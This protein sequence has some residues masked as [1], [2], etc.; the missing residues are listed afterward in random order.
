MFK[1]K[2]N[3][4][5]SVIASLAILEVANAN[6]T[7]LQVVQGGH[8]AANY[9][10]LEC[11]GHTT[12][13]ELQN[14]LWDTK[15]GLGLGG[16]WWRAYAVDYY[17]TGTTDPGD[18][19][20]TDFQGAR[21]DA[22]HTASY[23]RLHFNDFQAGST[24][25]LLGTQATANSVR[26]IDFN[27][28]VKNSTLGSVSLVNRDT[29]ITKS[30]TLDISNG[31]KLSQILIGG[32]MNNND[33]SQVSDLT[34]NLVVDRVSLDNSSVG[35][36]RDNYNTQGNGRIT[37][38]NLNNSSSVGILGYANITNVNVNGNSSIG[39]VTNTKITNLTLNNGSITGINGDASIS[40]L[41]VNNGGYINSIIN[42]VTIGNL[43]LNGTANIANVDINY[44]INNLNLNGSSSID[45]LANTGGFGTINLNGSTRVGT[46]STNSAIDN[47]T[48]GPD[49]KINNFNV[50]GKI[51][52]MHIRSFDAI[53]TPV[54]NASVG[55]LITGGGSVTINKDANNWNDG[56]W[57]DTERLGI[58]SLDRYMQYGG[59]KVVVNIGNNLKESADNSVYDLKNMLKAGGK[60]TVT[61]GATSTPFTFDSTDGYRFSQLVAAPGVK[62]YEMNNGA[63]FAL[64]LNA[65]TSY[66]SNLYKQLVLGVLRR[67][68]VTNNILDNMTTKTFHS[69]RYYNNDV[70]LRLAQY[71]M[72]RIQNRSSK[73]NKRIRQNQ[74]QLDNVRKRIARIT[75][76]SSKGQHLDKGYN[77]HELM[78]QLDEVMI[79]Y[80][81]RRDWRVFAVPYTTVG[82][83]D[84]GANNTLEVAGGAIVG[85]QR[86]LRNY[87]I[88]GVYLGY[89][90]TNAN[91]TLIN[92]NANL[93][94]NSLQAGITHFKSF[95]L[96][97]KTT[98]AFLRTT[99]RGGVDLPNFNMSYAADNGS[100]H[101]ISSDSAKSTVPLIWNAGV[102]FKA[103]ITNYQYKHNS[104]VSPEIS[105]SYDV[106]SGLPLKFMKPYTNIAGT[107]FYPLGGDERYGSTLWHLPQVGVGVRYYKMWGNTFRTNHRVG[108]KYNILDKQDISFR[109]GGLQ[110]T[111]TVTIPKLYG[112]VGSDFI[113]NVK[114]NHELSLGFDVLL[115]MSNFDKSNADTLNT[116][117]NG[118][119]G[120]V[121]FKY[122]YWFGGSDFITDKDGNAVSRE[123]YERKK[124]ENLKKKYR[125]P[126]PSKKDKKIVYIDG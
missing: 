83:T 93:Q 38:L 43:T 35:T 51:T 53:S 98:E 1:S 102:E 100:T 62:L 118:V 57:N 11:S 63:G 86:N 78:D 104:Y 15:A 29:G 10:K 112:N 72:A 69:D 114:K 55:T 58:K 40:N 109:L 74:S 37:N 41:T 96:N 108:M 124:K 49:A 32:G 105:V 48:V 3:L 30:F 99:L 4:A 89:E 21:W 90:Y 7:G 87:N 13:Q 113:W 56:P 59:S 103:G 23:R 120:N 44:K 16:L 71:E 34:K 66:G 91:T 95:S 76:E 52:N 42:N 70:S 116:W 33:Q 115:Y 50:T 123:A 60:T 126:K 110:D 8:P 27:I 5:L 12:L 25:F 85:L 61:S 106:I 46:L 107:N 82:Y 81:G 122:A 125:A 19:T 24:N 47:L 79:P 14:R 111:G 119:N 88:L 77:N 28:Y 84:F 73:Y 54:I 75:K 26:A 6:C 2:K 97:R 65:S 20:V 117:F 92:N 9:A 68:Q 121:N 39:Y 94:N 18:I 101:K 67:Q 22:A 31:S 80:T 64:G 45:Y 36:I 17:F